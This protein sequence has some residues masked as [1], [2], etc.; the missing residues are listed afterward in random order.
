M[1][2]TEFFIEIVQTLSCVLECHLHPLDKQGALYKKLLVGV[3]VKV[4]VRQALGC[5]VGQPHGMGTEGCG[6]S[7]KC[8]TE[9]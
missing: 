4:G 7:P 5:A 9:D 1:F 3:S 6:V 8:Y 2:P